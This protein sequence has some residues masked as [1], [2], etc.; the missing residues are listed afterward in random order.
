MH[1][2]FSFRGVVRNTDNLLAAEGEC[3]E[4]MNLRMKDGSLVPIGRP[5]DVA[6]LGYAYSR[7][8][9]HEAAGCYLCLTD[10]QN[11]VLHIYDKEWTLQKDEGGNVL[12]ASLSGVRNV[13]F[14]G[15]IACCIADTGIFYVLYNDGRY[16]WLGDRP[17]MPS[18]GIS[19]SSKLQ[20]MVTDNE[21]YVSSSDG[22]ESTW[23]YNAKGFLDEAIHVLNR[24]GHYV[25]RALFKF[26][27]RLYDG[28]YIA[29]SPAMYVSDDN[30]ISGIRRDDG[31]LQ[32]E[33]SGSST[34]SKYI[35]NVLGFKPK[36]TFS[37]I[38]L[39]NW[40]N[41]VVGID[42]FTTGSIMG[43]K[44]EKSRHG[45]GS[46][47]GDN[48]GAEYDVYT[49]KSLDELSGDITSAAHYY[50]IAEY[51]IEGR[52]VDTLDNVSQ[53][54]LVL[55]PTLA[56]D[57]CSYSSLAAS[58]SY[59]FN[60]R[61]HVAALKSW[62]MKGYDPLFLKNASATMAV[63][64]HIIVRTSI[65]TIQ[66]LSSVV[67]EY[68]NVELPF[69]DGVF[70]LSPLLSY[71]DSRAFEM[72][73]TLYDGS[74]Y[75]SR[76]FALTPHRY[77]DQAQYLHYCIL[78]YSVRYKAVL[79]NGN[80]VAPLR[81]AD[82]VA[83][84]SNVAGEHEIVYSSARGTWLYGSEPFPTGKYASLRLVKSVAALEDGDRILFIITAVS[85]AYSSAD[86]RNIP[87]DDSWEVVDG[88]VDT[89]ETNPYELRANVLKVSA[90]ENPFVFPAKCT[91]TPTQ[92]R[93]SALASNTVELSQGQFGQH[94]LF[95][96]CSDGIWAMSVDTSGAVAYLG[97][98]PL[99]REVC[100]NP[101]SVCGVDGGVVFVSRKG[102]MFISGGRLKNL[103]ACMDGA[104]DA[105]EEIFSNGVIAK[106]ISMMRLPGMPGAVG[107]EEYLS[108]AVIRYLP[109]HEELLVAQS[110]AGH[111][112]ICSLPNGSWSATDVVADGFVAH[113][114]SSLFFVNGTDGCKVKA[115]D[116]SYSGDN[117]VLILTRP[118]LWG[119][120]LPKRIIQLMLHS[121]AEPVAERTP[122]LPSIACYMFGSNDGVHFGLVAGREYD[123]ETQDL[124]FPYFPSR[125]YRYYLFAVCGELSS[126][127]RITGLE[128]EVMPA[129]NNRMR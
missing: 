103:S 7:I 39:D 78:G 98:Y 124:K 88:D 2:I 29:I 25:D 108:R 105:V 123:G 116:D 47:A 117:R 89:D 40:K 61:L 37:D 36:F 60:N 95:L 53:L 107:F 119:T 77:L 102:M 83:M 69:N 73:I 24:T 125:S 8:L 111:S 90:V 128:V 48:G 35:V 110:L 68:R 31:N 96:F 23:T 46:A 21:Y 59:V 51:D 42:L 54:N 32:S 30:E 109:A 43:K 99:S 62:F 27:L 127:S 49:V 122:G 6:T 118:Q 82:V 93:I 91:Y 76:T 50:R 100:V 71:P 34:P 22:V 87:V 129:W 85:D 4:V 81:D 113:A 28:S 80:R 11:P 9:W 104:A 120:K 33:A 126:Q 101:L 12:F 5:V 44:V 65:K 114:Q 14:L 75:V 86:I 97:S 115:F 70:E 10:E 92:G 106:I 84:F 55:Q 41:I 56:N 63:A 15:N 72:C 1:K 45:A 20:R 121:Y 67:R 64:E 79:S 58:C 74:R 112:Y 19:I 38:S 66:G 57:E 26:A 18:L 16:I 52:L 17:P 3:V 94:P 13:E